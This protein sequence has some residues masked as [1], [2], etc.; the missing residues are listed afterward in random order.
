VTIVL[1]G[2]WDSFQLH[3]LTIRDKLTLYFLQPRGLHGTVFIA[4]TFSADAACDGC[5]AGRHARN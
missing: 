4:I 3:S 5:G 1:L 2:R